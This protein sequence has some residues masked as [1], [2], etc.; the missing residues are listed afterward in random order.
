MRNTLCIVCFLLA[1]TAVAQVVTPTPEQ[2]GSPR[3]ENKGDYNVMESFETGYRFATVAGN[4][5]TYRAD[6]NYGNGIRLLSSNL[7]VNSKDG[8]G[9]FF[10][11]IV[12]TTVGLG[13]DPYQA[14]TLRIE[15][16]DPKTDELVP[17]AVV[18]FAIHSPA[19]LFRY[20][21]TKGGSYTF[22]L[23]R[24]VVNGKAEFTYFAQTR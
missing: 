6:V 5:G 14:V 20:E 19:L 13:D 16:I 24:R 7:S 1:R 21:Q 18:T 22:F 15:S 2:A 3:G 11:Q 9:R 12:L 4:D 10:D 17:G 8:H 23:D